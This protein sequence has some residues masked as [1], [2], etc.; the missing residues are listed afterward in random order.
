MPL[1][2][3]EP[4]TPPVPACV[5][6]CPVCGYMWVSPSEIVSLSLQ[7]HLVPGLAHVCGVN[8]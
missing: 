7:R 4:Q 1:G 6:V 5:W 8:E 3:P 2:F